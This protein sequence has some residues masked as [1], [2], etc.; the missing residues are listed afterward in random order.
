[1]KPLPTTVR[2]LLLPDAVSEGA[3]AAAGTGTAYSMAV[4][5][6]F[7]GTLGVA[8]DVDFVAVTLE[9]GTAYNFLGWGTGGAAAGVGDTILA[10]HS[11]TGAQLRVNDDI[12]TEAGNAFSL[13]EYTPTTSGTFYLSLRSFDGSQ[14][15]SYRIMALTDTLT[16]AQAATYITEL[17]WGVP[18]PL[19]FD[20]GASGRI[21]VDLTM[22]NAA[23]QQLA[24]WALE[25]WENVSGLD[26]VPISS[27]VA[28]IRFADNQDGAFAGPSEFDPDTGIIA[29]VAGVP[30]AEVNVATDWLNEYGTTLDSYSYQTYL[31]EIGHALGLGHAGPYDGNATYGVDNF[32]AN[33]STLLSVMSYFG[34]DANTTVAGGE[35]SILTPAMADILAVQSLYGVG[36]AHEGDT[37]WG[38][39]ATVGGWLGQIFA[40]V[41]DGAARDSAL[42]AGAA[43]SFTVYDTGGTDTLDFSTA[44]RAQRI[45]MRAG[46]VSDV[47]GVT[48][49]MAIALGVEIENALG[50]SAADRITG[51]SGANRITGGQGNDTIDGGAGSDTAVLNVTRASVTATTEGSAIRV[52]SALGTDLY[53]S[54]EFFAFSDGTVSAATLLG[55][56]TAPA[57]P[58]EGA[59]LLT[60][61]AGNDTL[62]GLGGNDTLTGAAGNDVLSGGTG[63]DLLDGG[64]GDDTL[65]GG[66]GDDTINGGTG[67]DTAIVAGSRAAA[68]ISRA[69]DSTTITSA[70][71]RDVYT[72]VEFFAFSDG[73]LAL[74]DLLPDDPGTGGVQIGTTGNDTLTG[75][76]GADSLF[77]LGGEDLISGLGGDDLLAGSDGDDSLDGG[78]GRDVIGGGP[79]NDDIQGGDGNDTIGAGQGDDTADGGAGNDIVNGGAGNDSLLG[80][81]GDDTMGASF[82]D[83]TA[84]G[85]AGNDSI[86]G[87]TGRDLL[88]GR[89][90]DDSIGGG[91]GNDTVHGGDGDDFLA[92]GGRD[93]LLDGGNGN[94]RLNGGSGNDTL[95]G[96]DGFDLFIFNELVAGEV[97]VI[98]D[99]EDCCDVIRLTGVTGAGAQGRFDALSIIDVAGGAELSYG[100]HRILLAGI[101][102]ADLG[103]EDFAFL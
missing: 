69:G 72:G 11:A 59:D 37:T 89:E 97:D 66:P 55:E 87:G 86:G 27:G 48:G 101:T 49:G 24:F 46:T 100:G 56:D 39:N 33:D 42:Y 85:G 99:F 23:G 16:P 40:M 68:S 9:A 102:T 20:P 57:G 31:H 83:D 32:Y 71:G 93:D 15:G 62:A 45:D 96:G 58:T 22:L 8:S 34:P 50:G 63:N 75:S 60:G 90:G 47:N 1:M 67:S 64:A 29:P 76:E 73:T 6:I 84:D 3:D 14:A 10:V 28:D 21:T 95:T 19:R 88:S 35:L 5:D 51:T 54:I 103:A 80:G 38:A 4:G 53:T 13:L 61:T 74:A 82:G 26:F 25:A 78:S 52:V 65:D 2:H 44:T 17:D 43:T 77:G 70:E 7:A 30:G 12:D 36:S 91:E 94:D 18:V 81:E 41:F 98:T 79:G 92:G